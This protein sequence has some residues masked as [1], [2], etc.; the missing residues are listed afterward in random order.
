VATGADIMIYTL[1]H[2]I[3]SPTFDVAG[4]PVKV[5]DYAYIGARAIVFP[6]CASA[7]ELSLPPGQW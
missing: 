6:A 4:G 7:W 3:D 1:Q 2:D 5:D